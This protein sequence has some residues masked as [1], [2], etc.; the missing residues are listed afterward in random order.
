MY[1]TSSTIGSISKVHRPYVLFNPDIGEFSIFW[2]DSG[3]AL[4]PTA[5][6]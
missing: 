5:Q 4:V 2:E 1:V 6:Y 3:M